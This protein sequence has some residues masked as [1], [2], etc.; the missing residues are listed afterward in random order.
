M[1]ITKRITAVLLAFA[2]LIS[3]MPPVFAETTDD[4]V[5]PPQA[6]GISSTSDQVIAEAPDK[7]ENALVVNEQSITGIPTLDAEIKNSAILNYID[8]ETLAKG[9]HISR[10]PELE[11]LSSYVFKNADGTRTVYYMDHPVKYLDSNGTVND[12]NLTIHL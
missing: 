8:S 1:K 10:C 6:T 3:M 9:G 5:L 12:I 2:L 7:N 4:T 11:T